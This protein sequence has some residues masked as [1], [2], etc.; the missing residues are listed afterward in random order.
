MSH[1]LGGLRR[2]EV[3]A[4]ADGA[5]EEVLHVLTGKRETLAAQHRNQYPLP[6]SIVRPKPIFA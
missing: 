6:R 4:M 5:V 2:D 3:Q 1:P